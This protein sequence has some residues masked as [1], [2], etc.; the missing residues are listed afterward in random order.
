MFRR[1]IIALAVSWAITGFVPADAAGTPFTTESAGGGAPQSTIQPS[2]ALT[3]LIRIVGDS[4]NDPSIGEVTFF[5]GKFAP[6]GCAIA[7]GQLLSIGSNS[8][9]FSIPGTTYGGDGRTTFALPDLRGRVAVGD[10]NGPG[11]SSRPLGQKS[12]VENVSLP[13]S[14][15]DHVLQTPAIGATDPAGGGDQSYTNMQPSLSLN[16]VMPLEGIFSSRSSGVPAEPMIGFVELYASTDAKTASHVHGLDPLD[17]FAPGDTDPTDGGQSQTNMQPTVA[18]QYLVAVNA[19]FPAGGTGEDPFL[20]EIGLFAGNFLPGGWLEAAG[21][22][23]SITQN[24]ALFSLFGTIY[25]G[26]GETTFAL[27]DLRGR[28][29]LGAGQGPG[30]MNWQLGRKS[31]VEDNTMSVGQLQAHTHDYEGVDVVEPG[32]LAIFGLGLAGLGFL[33][34][35][36]NA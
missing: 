1:S 6:V 16:Y 31:G 23:R 27:P 15:H 22:L 7:K 12:G 32:T 36:H 28:V 30:L 5:G 18:I 20:G 24:P 25:G 29:A 34:R 3:P 2:L 35:R 9:L 13:L 10:G 8:A 19:S 21:Q 14:N 17:P 26:D 33:R 4:A 11:L